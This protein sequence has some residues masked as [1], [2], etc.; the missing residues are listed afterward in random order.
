LEAEKLA[1]ITALTAEITHE[2]G[3]PMTAI[4]GYAELIAKSVGE[5]KNRKRATTI[6]EQVARVRDLIET[7]MNL[8][9]M[10]ERSPFPLELAGILD[11]ALDFYREK[12]KRRGIEIERHYEPAPRILGDPG[13]L[14]QVLLG[15]FLNALKAMPQEGTL[16]VTLAGVGNAEVEVRISGSGWSIDP[17]LRARI[18]E[19]YFSTRQHAGGPGLRLFVAKT[20]I[21]EHGGQMALVSESDRGTEFRL[22]FPQ[23]IEAPRR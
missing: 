15:L 7:L 17:S 2:I 20:L 1:A 19:P 14:H 9:R 16:R 3:T 21:E 6:V 23:F 10:E 8:S 5:E 18:F 13:Q 22:T 11:K 4:L 12:F